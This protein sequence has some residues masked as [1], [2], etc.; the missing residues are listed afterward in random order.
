MNSKT[1]ILNQIRTSTWRKRIITY[2]A[3]YA[4]YLQS[5]MQ[6]FAAP[7][8]S[9][10][11]QEGLSTN[12]LFERA[13]SSSEYQY[14]T[15]DFME[16]SAPAAQTLAGFY[17]EIFDNHKSI[18]GEPIYVPI[19]VG[20]ITTIIPI[21]EKPKY[22]GSPLVQS[23]Y[24]R[25]QIRNLLGRNLIDGDDSDY[26]SELA[27]INTLYDNAIYFIQY[28]RPDVGFG[29][30]LELD[31]EA[32]GLAQ[33]IVWPEYRTIHGEQVLV[34]VVYLTQ[35]TVADRRVNEHVV[36]LPSGAKFNNLSIEGV[37]V[38]LGRDAF[39]EVAG[40]L[41]NYQGSITGSGDMQIVASGRL[42]N[43]S[44]VI[45][46]EGDLVIGAHSV[47]S[48]TLVHRYD[49]GTSQGARFGQIS[50]INSSTGDVV[51]R[52]FSDIIIQGGLVNAGGGDI[53]FAADGNIYIGPVSFTQHE[54][55][56]GGGWK[57][58]TTLTQHLISSLTA[59]DS[60]EIVAQ[61][62]IKIDAAEI[63]ANEGHI[64]M[65]AGMGIEVIDTVQQYQRSYF[66]KSSSLTINESAY[67][68][69]AMRSLLDAGKDIRLHTEFGDVTLRSV[70]ISSVG[71]TSVNAANGAINM[72][73]TV[74]SDHYSYSS[75]K[76]SL[77]TI[78]TV[79]R[80]HNIETAVPNTIIGGFQ[81]EA[82]YGLNVEYE[83]D[84]EL[85]L[86]QQVQKLSE[87]EGLEWMSSIR[88]D[89]PD[90]DWTAID[91]AYEEWNEQNTSLSPAALA[92]ITIVV[93]VVTAGA[94]T[95]VAGAVGAKGATAAAVA[96]G[97]SA[98]ISQVSVAVA[99]GAVNGDVGGA[100]E[101]LASSDTLRT[102]A[103]S[104]VTAG[105]MHSI[106]AKF[107]TNSPTTDE[108]IQEAAR[109]GV[110]VANMSA[111]QF[112]EIKDQLESLS[113][114]TQAIQ[115]VTNASVSAGIE[116]FIS[117]GDLSDFGD[118][119][120]SSVASNSINVLGR[121]VAEQIGAAAHATPPDISLA[122]QY[123]AH[124]ALGCL[125]GSLNASMS[126]S[127]MENSCLSGAGGAVI[128]E[129]I[130]NENRA[131]LNRQLHDD[132][133]LWASEYLDGNSNPTIGEFNDAV[134]DFLARG[135]DA[136]KLAAAFAVFAFGGE[137]NIAASTAA[138]AARHNSSSRPYAL[139]AAGYELL[140]WRNANVGSALFEDAYRT[141]LDRM[142]RL[143]N[144]ESLDIASD[145]FFQA[146]LERNPTINNALSA[147]GEVGMNNLS[148]N[149]GAL[150]GLLS[151]SLGAEVSEQ[152]Y[153]DTQGTEQENL[154]PVY[155]PIELSSSEAASFV[156]DTKS[157]LRDILYYSTIRDV[158]GNIPEYYQG[159]INDSMRDLSDSIKGLPSV[160]QL[161]TDVNSNGT[162]IHLPPDVDQPANTVTPIPDFTPITLLIF[163][164]WDS[165]AGEFNGNPEGVPIP[166]IQL[167]T[168]TGGNQIIDLA[169]DA[170][171]LYSLSEEFPNRAREEYPREL[172]E[173]QA[174]GI[175]P[176]SADSEEFEILA[177]VGSPIKWVVTTDGHL[178]I[179][180]K[181]FGSSEVTHAVAASGGSVIAAGEASIYESGGVIEGLYINRWSGHYE[182]S[183]ESLDIGVSKFGEYGITFGEVDYEIPGN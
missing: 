40:D 86:D 130:A 177:S 92:V 23:R 68:T 58:E 85:T 164:A 108:V 88:S 47:D 96:A 102:L 162:L 124:A 83:G 139:S 163:E 9:T 161:I 144:G 122:S 22:V 98:L 41:R 53:Q 160:A 48:Q 111:E 95:A 13:S 2:V 159:K 170:S 25:Y 5:A 117:G 43:L 72:L 87:F 59:A 78:R 126:A 93:A 169:P 16:Q 45:Q 49:F 151:G 121:A 64:E 33:N 29:E 36:E 154:L 91:L 61:G 63:V 6:A 37:D 51:L 18:L 89:Y 82:L 113:L 174:Q 15:N 135:I 12:P 138:N 35:S 8:A 46:A 34:P 105:F 28:E 65:L 71:G 56:S 112:L 132:V 17:A 150:L 57:K 143:L 128:G 97:T 119:F 81:A 11:I 181:E 39:L 103:I 158:N 157:L 183:A 110:D 73:M 173:A 168:N 109:Q 134:E 76:E 94:G 180:P 84:P 152:Y 27:Q 107:F 19:G 21:Y 52:S 90:V 115:A 175:V 67:R 20:D 4:L 100:L 125:S 77:F 75:V 114:G 141:Y 156:E 106:D 54:E 32:S 182:P 129:Y 145:E 66:N 74:E 172:A 99:N 123:F 118:S 178:L 10:I 166:D 70:D 153:A 101:D 69:V 50:E 149:I 26:E 137:V 142:L 146:E 55:A 148:S 133:K 104:M 179:I 136:G 31:Q 38:R 127:D 30:P 176:V 167:P 42:E 131:E 80:G 7:L 14:I 62:S 1:T 171:I 140:K 155:E 3:V 147:I 116:T 60:L 165:V 44:G 120:V 24:I 79:N